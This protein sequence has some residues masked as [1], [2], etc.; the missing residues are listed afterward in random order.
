MTPKRI[1]LIG[2]VYPYRAGIA[3]CTTRLGEELAK[4]CDVLLVSFRRQFPKRF[5]PGGDDRDPSLV[6]KTPAGARFRLDILNPIT[7]LREGLWLRRQSPDVVLFT[8]W[9]WVWALPYLVIRLFLPPTTKIVLQCHNIRDKEPAGWKTFL[10]RLF[11]RRADLL[12]VHSGPE[13]AAARQLVSSR[14]RVEELFL[15]VHE[16]GE[17]APSKEDAR[18]TLHLATNDQVALFFGHVRPFKGLDIALRAW[19]ALGVPAILVVAGEVW[20]DDEEQ[21]RNLVRELGIED[22]VRLD[23]RFIPDSE[24]ATFFAAAD[25]VLAPYRHEAQSG[26][27]L[28]AFHFHRPVIAARVGGLPEIVIEGETG[29]LIDPESPSGLAAAVD[30]FFSSSDRFRLEEGAGLAAAKYSWPEFGLLLNGMMFPAVDST[31]GQE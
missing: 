29:L 17:R 28:T 4:S 16:L 15:P 22:R 19:A 6:P 30:R 9:V 13:T 23:F 27:A 24:I 11:L 1:A 10:T 25:V 26:V 31:R 2:P 8:W 12:V 18:A 14:T 5:Y 20:W 7:W 21:Y 3:Y